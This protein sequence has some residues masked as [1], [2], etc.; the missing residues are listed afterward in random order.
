MGDGEM[1]CF[2]PAAVYLRKP[3]RE[4]IEVQN[5]PLDAK[6]AIFMTDADEEGLPVN[7]ESCNFKSPLKDS[8]GCLH[9]SQLTGKPW[10]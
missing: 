8:S 3:E 2:G 7:I 1:E 5:T 10:G 4:R 6:S 9:L